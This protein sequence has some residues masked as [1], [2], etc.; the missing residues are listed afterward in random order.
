MFLECSVPKLFK[1]LH[2]VT[3]LLI[4]YDGPWSPSQVTRLTKHNVVVSCTKAFVADGIQTKEHASN[5]VGV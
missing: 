2:Y 4:A 3:S 5:I 1:F